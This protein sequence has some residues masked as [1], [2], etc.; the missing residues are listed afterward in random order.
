LFEIEQIVRFLVSI[1][2]KQHYLMDFWDKVILVDNNDQEIGEKDKMQAHLD[3]DLHR[4][5]S[6]F[7]FNSKNEILLQKR[8]ETKYHSPGLWT[9]TCCSHPQPG[10]AMEKC[11]EHRLNIEMGMTCKLMPWFTF[12]YKAEFENG[13][14]EHEF[15]HVYKGFSDELPILN[16]E[17]ASDYQYIT[18]ENLKYELTENPQQY[19]AWLKLIIDRI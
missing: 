2:I 8:A 10:I 7:I 4:A 5:F 3:G 12:K 14:I 19:T 13:L 9:N 17:E 6:I 18:V 15:D 11:L 1:S 16:A